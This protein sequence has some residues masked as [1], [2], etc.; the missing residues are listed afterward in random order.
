MR[1][2]ECPSSN[3]FVTSLATGIG[4]VE[5]FNSTIFALATAFALVGDVGR[6]RS[7]ASS[8]KQARVLNMI[9]RDLNKKE[10]HIEKDHYASC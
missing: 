4:L 6:C 10:L 7:Q 2:E 1:L 3:S 8:W 9:V 5:G